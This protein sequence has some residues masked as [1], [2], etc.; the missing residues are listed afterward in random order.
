MSNEK[1]LERFQY[2]TGSFI[3]GKIFAEYSFG[4]SELFDLTVKGEKT[5]QTRTIESMQNVTK[6]VNFISHDLIRV[7]CDL[8]I[9]QEQVD[10][11]EN[12]IHDIVS[13]DESDQKRVM[14]LVKKIKREKNKSIN[15]F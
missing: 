13:L 14:G 11:I 6:Y 8:G 15:T 2:C 9:T 7:G 1:L 12:I 10:N 5:K 3:S 4:L